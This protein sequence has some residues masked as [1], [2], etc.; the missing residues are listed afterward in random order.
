MIERNPNVLIERAK[1]WLASDPDDRTSRATEAMIQNKDVALLE[2]H[3]GRQLRFGTAGIR[4]PLGP[5]PNCMNRVTVQRVTYG[6]GV[7]LERINGPSKVVIGF[8]GRHGSH[9]FA[10]DAAAVLGTLGHTVYLHEETIPTPELAYAVVHMSADIGIM[11]TASHNPPADNGYKVYWHNGAQI[12]PPHDASIIDSMNGVDWA[13]VHIQSEDALRDA[14]R[15]HAVPD[16]VGASY[17]ERVLELVRKE[18]RRLKIVYTPLHGVAYRR[19]DEVLKR[20]GFDD[21]HVV[22]EQRDPDPDFTT[23]SFPNPE[24]PLAL[25]MAKALGTKLDADIVIAND[26][27]GDRLAV[28]VPTQRGWR[29]L[30]GNE[31]GILL[32]DDRMTA[33][34]PG[35]GMVATTIVSTPLLREMAQAYDVGYRETLTGFKWIANA[36]IEHE[37]KGGEFL[38]GFEVA[39]GY[40]IG[41]IVRDKD[42]IS[43]ALC[44]C[45]M[46]A[47]A[48]RVNLSRCVR[49]YLSYPWTLRFGQYS[50]RFEGIDGAEQMAQLMRDLRS[51]RPVHFSNSPLVEIRDGLTRSRRFLNGGDTRLW[52]IPKSDVLCWVYEDG[53]TLLAR[54][55]GTEPKIKVYAYVRKTLGNSELL[56][57]VQAAGLREVQTLLQG[58]VEQNRL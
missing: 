41:N 7:Y 43:A 27:D 9:R 54:P 47:H 49:A 18:T 35:T 34:S 24:H 31:I 51:Q 3:F 29:Q 40:T 32:A 23:V 57:D 11:V 33:A 36:G 14:K 28:C 12:I 2:Q 26:P 56:S 37:K 5:G 4:G 52:D 6:L 17:V 15:I 45:V 16:A 19:L 58:V 21:I 53:T 8:D 39:L 13:S 25:T 10:R 30:T 38:F 50:T 42:G 20:A 44:L 1:D 48:R 55:S 22:V 46:A